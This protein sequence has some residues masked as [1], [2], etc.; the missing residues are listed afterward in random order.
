MFFG[1]LKCPI[2]YQPTKFLILKI[3]LFTFEK[4]KILGVPVLNAKV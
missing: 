4:V 1:A 3:E 2:L